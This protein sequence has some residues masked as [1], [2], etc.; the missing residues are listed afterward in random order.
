[1]LFSLFWS[2]FARHD[3]R[4]Y[5]YR[6]LRLYPES[7]FPDRYN[8]EFTLVR[9][10]HYKKQCVLHRCFLIIFIRRGLQI[11]LHFWNNSIDL[12]DSNSV[13][14]HLLQSISIYFV[15]NEMINQFVTKFFVGKLTWRSLQIEMSLQDYITTTDIILKHKSK[16]IFSKYIL[17]VDIKCKKFLC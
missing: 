16:S 10:Q 3:T 4:S 9:C 14:V 12:I 2:C 6:T 11:F 8:P 1:M 7:M 13:D 15:E 5:L 17:N